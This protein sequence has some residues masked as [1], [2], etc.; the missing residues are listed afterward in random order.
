MENVLK[1]VIRL[2]GAVLVLFFLFEFL[3]IGTFL[4][5]HGL[6]SICG[7]CDRVLSLQ[8]PWNEKT[9]WWAF[10]IIGLIV[11]EVV[12]S[13]VRA[14]RADRFGIKHIKMVRLASAVIAIG[15]GALF[16]YGWFEYPDSPLGPCSGQTGYCGKQ[17]QPHTFAEHQAYDR[18]QL[19]LVIVWPLGM[20]G[21]FLLNRKDIFQ[22]SMSRGGNE[23]T[24]K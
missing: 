8:I 19:A 7:Y 13:A 3:Q 15:M 9:K 22:R 2:G 17:G 20:L 16:L 24:S 14:I 1:G 12:L 5:G 23:S 21:L 6:Q 18:L 10:G 11:T 4:H